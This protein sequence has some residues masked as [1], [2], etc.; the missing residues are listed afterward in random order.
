[1]NWQAMMG[2]VIGVSIGSFIGNVLPVWRRKRAE[3]IVLIARYGQQ[4]VTPRVAVS[5]V[6]DRSM[7]GVYEYPDDE[8]GNAKASLYGQGL[9]RA[10]ER[11][12]V[13]E[14]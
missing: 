7:Q 3:P 12:L 14:R 8:V 2:V 1:M 10:M 5:A 6:G 11:K 9:A 4:T 13:D